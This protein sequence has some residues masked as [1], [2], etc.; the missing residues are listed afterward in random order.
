M[1]EQAKL[2]DWFSSFFQEEGKDIVPARRCGP[3]KNK[4]ILLLP[5]LKTLD[6]NKTRKGIHLV[7]FFEYRGFC[8]ILLRFTLYSVI[9][10]AEF[11]VKHQCLGCFSVHI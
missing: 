11:H 2:G 10:L 7:F 3:H 8:L 1:A 5:M 6:I 4:I 9:K